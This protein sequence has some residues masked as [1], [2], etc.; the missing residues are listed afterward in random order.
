MCINNDPRIMK[1]TTKMLTLLILV[2]FLYG[3]GTVGV[4]DRNES[5][6]MPKSIAMSIFEK[7]GAR[8]WAENPYFE[9]SVSLCGGRVSAGLERIFFAQY[10]P[11]MKQL[12]FFAKSN[13]FFC[14][15]VLMPFVNITETE[16]LELT[17]AAR[18]LGATKL[19]KLS[20]AY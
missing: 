10:M 3:C 16:A 15:G 6:M 7:H 18:A 9:G 11:Q 12:V 17:N 5:D 8:E 20:W 13:K 4:I 14:P 1:N 19:E 2:L